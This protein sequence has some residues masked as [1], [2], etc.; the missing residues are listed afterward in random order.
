MQQL[1][2]IRGKGNKHMPLSEG[3]DLPTGVLFKNTWTPPAEVT[4]TSYQTLE[5]KD[6][7]SPQRHV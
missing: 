2:Q 6:A 1:G 5:L 4:Y 3:P 7:R